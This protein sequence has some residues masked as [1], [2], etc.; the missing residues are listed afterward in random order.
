[1]IS[2]SS[3]RIPSR[4]SHLQPNITTGQ[5]SYLA[6]GQALSGSNCGVIQFDYTGGVSSTSNTLKLG[7]FG[8]QYLSI[9][10]L[11][12]TTTSSLT[13]SGSIY[14]GTFCSSLLRPCV[15]VYMTALKNIANDTVTR[16]FETIG[17][18][19][20]TNSN[21]AGVTL[22][23]Y[24][25]TTGWFLNVS[26]R[27]LFVQASLLLCWDGFNGISGL[28]SSAFIVESGGQTFPYGLISSGFPDESYDNQCYT[29]Q[30]PISSAVYVSVKQ[31]SGGN[32]TIQAGANPLGNTFAALSMFKLV[33]LN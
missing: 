27:E 33:V 30:M 20:P 31:T 5:G 32:L 21:A 1:V 7:P 14:S 22:L 17:A 6:V 12:N 26:G 28:R 19:D 15:A 29:I 2:K 25:N 16:P 13:A 18:I 23:T 9:D 11:G 24:D 4:L 10:G 3:K 8:A